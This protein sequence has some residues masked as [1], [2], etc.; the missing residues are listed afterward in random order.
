MMGIDQEK[1]CAIQTFAPD[2]RRLSSP[3]QQHPQRLGVRVGPLLCRHFLGGWIQP[4]HVL[5]TDIFIECSGQKPAA[6]KKR[7]PLADFNQSFGEFEQV[8]AVRIDSFPIE[9]TDLIVLSIGVIVSALRSGR[10][11]SPARIMGVPRESSSVA[12]KFLIC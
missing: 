8:P 10:T 12:S 9:P 4:S 5:D 3:V 1:Q 11:S 2:S 6:V 7:L